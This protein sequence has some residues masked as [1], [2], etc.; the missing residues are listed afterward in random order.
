MKKEEKFLEDHVQ[1]DLIHLFQAFSSKTRLN[2]LYVLKKQALTVTEI[3][4]KLQ[5]SQSAISHQLRRLKFAR[6]VRDQRDGRKV[7]Y[8]LTDK[9]IHD[10][11]DLAIEHVK[12]IYHY[13]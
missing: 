8:T 6:L 1:E 5:M 11:F 13:E 7:I 10:I 3:S 2:I 9:H 4:E 12:E